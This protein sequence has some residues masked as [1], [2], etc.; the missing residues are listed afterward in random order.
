MP[1]QL[2][3]TGRFERILLATDGSPGSASAE[4][5]AMAMAKAWSAQ[6]LMCTVVISNP[7]AEA[8]AMSEI[9]AAEAEAQTL[10]KRLLD[11][12]QAQGIQARIVVPHG[13]D[14]LQE[15]VTLADDCNADVIVM[16]RHPQPGWLRRLLGVTSVRA[17]AAA[18]CSVL[19]VPEG[20]SMW[21][22]RILLATDG[23]RFSEAAGVAAGKLATLGQ[24]PVTVVSAIRDSF[25][26]ERAEQAEQA[27]TAVHEHLLAQGVVSTKEVLHGPP[28]ALILGTAALRKADIIVVGTHGRTGW[29]RLVV[30]SVTESVFKAS[31]VPVLAV[32]L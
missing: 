27:A 19:L 21:K 7:I 8:T 31:K 6:L 14:P 5:V 1:N 2:S 17:V 18:S 26:A 11:D 24:L 30:G 15:I 20:A 23:S 12:A 3:P 4:Q 16:G 32:K 22:N 25:T 29:E 9:A 10:L 28:D 13:P